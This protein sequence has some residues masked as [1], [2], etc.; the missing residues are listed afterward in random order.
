MV[1]RVAVARVNADFP[2]LQRYS[3]HDVPVAYFTANPDVLRVRP[4]GVVNAA[5]GLTGPVAPLEII[6]IYGRGLS[7]PVTFDGIEAVTTHVSLAQINATVPAAV[8]GRSET[9]L[10]VGDAP[11]VTLPVA[12]AAPGVFAIVNQDGSLNRPET[13]AARGSVATVYGTGGSTLAPFATS[14]RIGGRDAEVLYAGPA[15]TLPVSVLQVNVRVPSDI[16]AGN[17]RV[18]L[19]VAD[20]TGALDVTMA[21]R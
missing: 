9:V 4:F 21:V 3:D 8:A 2:E 18:V 6:S 14:V 11:A 7:A 5:T 19:S 17:A 20:A 12:G 15:A 1:T 16:A 10:Q 13:P